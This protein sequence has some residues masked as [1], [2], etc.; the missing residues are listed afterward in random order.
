LY[1]LLNIF[2]T[3]ASLNCGPL[4][5][6]VDPLQQVWEGLHVLGRE[7]AALPAFDPRPCLD[8][9]DAVFAL[10]LAG[11]VVSWLACVFA[12]QADLEDAVDAEGF[13]LVSVDGV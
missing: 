10:A 8:V 7:A 11:E 4:R 5:N 9:G 3:N 6:S 2:I 12:G 1:L 13:V